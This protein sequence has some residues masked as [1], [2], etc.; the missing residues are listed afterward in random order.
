MMKCK[1]KDRWQSIEEEPKYM[2]DIYIKR[3]WDR[4]R[5]RE[6]QMVRIGNTADNSA[7][8]ETKKE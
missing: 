4:Q 2:K 7:N 8:Y 3:E 1:E 5:V 6:R